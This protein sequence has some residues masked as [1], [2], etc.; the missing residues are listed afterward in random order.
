MYLDHPCRY[1][2]PACIPHVSCISDTYLSRY[3]WDTCIPLCIL[4]VFRMYPS[5]ILEPLQIHLSRMYPACILHVSCMS[6][7]CLL[8]Y[9]RT[10]AD[11]CIPYVSHMLSACIPHVSR[12]YPACIPYVSRMDP[13]C[14]ARAFLLA[15]VPTLHVVRYP[16]TGQLALPCEGNPAGLECVACKSCKGVGICSHVLTINHMMKLFN[17]RFQLKSVQTNALKKAGQRGSR[18]LLPALQRAPHVAPDS[19]DEEAERLELLGQQGR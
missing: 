8:M 4:E 7:A 18:K 6:F 9:P 5:C 12:M 2:Y 3:I 1:M 13:S 17:V 15:G 14:I 19:S 16:S 11:T 10:S